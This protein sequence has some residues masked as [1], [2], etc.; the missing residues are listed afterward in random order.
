[1]AVTLP[2]VLIACELYL[3]YPRLHWRMLYDKI[4]HLAIA[5]VV[6]VV[7]IIGQSQVRD[8]SPLPGNIL[9]GLMNS[10]KLVTLCLAKTVW[11]N[12][13]SVIYES[14]AV[15]FDWLLL[16][17]AA[18][19][20]LIFIGA[21]LRM[22]PWRRDALFGLAF[23]GIT[24]LPVIR[25]VQF[26]DASLFNDRFFYLP[27]IGLLFAFVALTE[28]MGKA[29]FSTRYVH[30]ILCAFWMALI[31]MMSWATFQRCR[32]W[33][34]DETLFLDALHSYPASASAH[35]FLAQ[36]YSSMGRHRE[37]AT[38]Y[39]KALDVA[40]GTPLRTS[41]LAYSLFFDGKK[42][43]A[44]TV[45][46]SAK[47]LWPYNAEGLYTTALFFLETDQLAYARDHLRNA[48]V[49]PDTLAGPY[50]FVQKARIYNTLAV[51]AYRQ[52]S[53]QEALENSSLALEGGAL[54]PETHYNRG[55]ILRALSRQKE[56]EDAM[57]RALELNPHLTEALADLAVIHWEEGNETAAT[58][59]MERA[60]GLSPDNSRYRCNLGLFLWTKG[61]LAEAEYQ[62][63]QALRV[64]PASSC[65]RQAAIKS[66]HAA[67]GH[68]N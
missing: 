30:G 68:N 43:D 6:G 54:L 10:V 32:V 3:D 50:R 55:L 14:T 2:L 13:L 27:G 49:A 47:S 51:I 15:T 34:N 4:P 5:V 1:M 40:P 31:S 62:F 60:V 18:L 9:T 35:S 56:A 36:Y 58:N 11:P 38:H 8:G 53:W 16:L 46:A 29:L 61:R 48:L 44:L 20:P 52:K 45:I 37:A 64:D 12:Q 17:C 26:G 41:G 21:F 7:T 24:L 25:V 22:L 57:L 67:D 66:E 42:D 65:A 59:E 39:Q 23:F 33:Q 28:A 19:I 63:N